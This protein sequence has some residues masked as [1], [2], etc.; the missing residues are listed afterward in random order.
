MG[1]FNTILKTFV[2][3]KAKKDLRLILPTVD[4]IKKIGEPGLIFHKSEKR[5]Y[6]HNNLFSQITGFMSRHQKPQS[7]IF[8]SF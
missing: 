3:D 5:V 2:G 6:P 4:E 1:L 7:K 8:F